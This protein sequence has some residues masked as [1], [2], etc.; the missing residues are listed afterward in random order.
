MLLGPP[1]QVAAVAGKKDG[2]K[3]GEAGGILKELGYSADQVG[4]N[5]HKFIPV[6]LNGCIDLQI[7]ISLYV[8]SA[9]NNN[10]VSAFCCKVCK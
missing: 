9:N 2:M 8:D 7:L 5:F 1:G 6:L 3:Q 10:A 4:M